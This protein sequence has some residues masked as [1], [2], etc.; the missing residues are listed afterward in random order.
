WGAQRHTSVVQRQGRGTD[1]THR[2]RT[3]RPEGLGDLTNRVWEVV[4]ARQHRH[5]GTLCE[6]SVANLAALRRTHAAGLARTEGREVVVVH[7]ALLR[8]RV[9]GVDLLLHLEHVQR[10]DTHDLGLAALEDG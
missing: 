5:Q 2:G 6:R 1:R 7:V 10:G 4:A 3:V 9:K 8:L